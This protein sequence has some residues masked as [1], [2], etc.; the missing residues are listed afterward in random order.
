MATRF[1]GGCLC[2]QVRYE[3]SADPLFM[4]NCHCRDCQKASGGAYE[5][6]IG[7]PAAALKI[8]GAVKYYDSKADSGNTLSRGFCPECGASLFGKTSA[9]PDLAMITAGSLDDPSLYK[10]TLDIFTA[11]AQPW[12][13]MNPALAKFPK[14]PPM[15]G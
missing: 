15:G 11:S 3:C 6:D 14:M 5:P 1:T 10:P 4:G 7:L 2:G 12:D 13:H 8:T 9:L